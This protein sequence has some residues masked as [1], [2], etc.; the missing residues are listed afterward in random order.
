MN[1]EKKPFKFQWETDPF[2]HLVSIITSFIFSYF[3]FPQNLS[4]INMMLLLLFMNFISVNLVSNFQRWL[5]Q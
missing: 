3:V 1:Q 4:S 5:K 2:L